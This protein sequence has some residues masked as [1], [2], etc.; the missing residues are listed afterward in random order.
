MGS[1][2]LGAMCIFLIL[3]RRRLYGGMGIGC[4]RG[5]GG[6]RMGCA[7]GGENR[8]GRTRAP[9][10]RGNGNRLCAGRRGNENGNGLCVGRRES[11]WQNTEWAEQ[12]MADYYCSL[13]K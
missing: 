6:M 5:G 7:R 8:N 12:G 10:V 2:P 9:A 3:A 4:A 11:E 13:N 1:N